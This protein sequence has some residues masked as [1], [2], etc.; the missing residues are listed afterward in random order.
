MVETLT[1]ESIDAKTLIARNVNAS[2]VNAGLLV[3]LRVDGAVTTKWTAL[4]ALAAGSAF[5]ATL[6]LLP[7]LLKGLR[8]L[9]ARL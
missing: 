3:A 1:A 8:Q 5:A 9:G 4:T 7:R 2:Q 6:V